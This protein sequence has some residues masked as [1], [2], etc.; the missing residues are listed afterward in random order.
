ML[1]DGYLESSRKV[2]FYL[3]DHFKKYHVWYH[4]E[5]LSFHLSSMLWHKFHEYITCI[6]QTRK[7]VLFVH[8][9][10]K[11]HIAAENNNI[12]PFEKCAE[13]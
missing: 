6:M 5:E 9:Y 1:Y 11:T 8:V 7:T 12:L 3:S 4:F 2:F 13:H 10:W